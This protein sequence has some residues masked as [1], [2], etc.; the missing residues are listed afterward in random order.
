MKKASLIFIS[1]FSQIL[2]SCGDQKEV[3]A[4]TNSESSS[5]RSTDLKAGG[6][7][8]LKN[9][10]GSYSISKILVLDDFAVHLRTYLGH[11]KTMPNDINT[12]TLKIM[13]GH[14]PLD[15]EGFL[16]DNP[17]LLKVEKVKENELEGY[18]LYMEEMN[19]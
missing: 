4:P 10:D 13:I 17:I 11:Y 18:K 15:R 16:L 8:A 3:S 6:V 1:I 14:A 5:A 12:D 9:K 7:Y 2:I 19:K